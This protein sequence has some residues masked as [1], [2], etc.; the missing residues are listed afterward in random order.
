MY[1]HPFAVEPGAV[2]ASAVKQSLPI[3]QLNIYS[4][5]EIASRFVP[6][7]SQ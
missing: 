5:I 6:R 3:I 1:F 2:I 4:I 7:G